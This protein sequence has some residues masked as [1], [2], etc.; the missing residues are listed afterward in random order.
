M[1][2]VNEYAPEV[3]SIVPLLPRIVH[4]SNMS[5]A[6]VIEANIDE[7]VWTRDG[8]DQ[9]AALVR[10]D[11]TDRDD[12]DSGSPDAINMRIE[13][14]R[15]ITATLATS[16][17]DY[18]DELVDLGANSSDEE[19]QVG[20]QQPPSDILMFSID[21]ERRLSVYLDDLKR[22]ALTQSHDESS[23]SS[24]PASTS[25]PT[26]GFDQSI[27]IDLPLVVAF[28][29][30]LV[31]DKG[32]MS[33]KVNL[34]VILT[35][36]RTRA[37]ELSRLDRFMTKR[38]AENWQSLSHPNAA[39]VGNNNNKLR[40]IS[41]D[42]NLRQIFANNQTA[43]IVLTIVLAFLALVLIMLVLVSIVYSISICQLF[44]GSSK[45]S[46]SNNNNKNN[47]IGKKCK[48]VTS[49]SSSSSSSCIDMDKSQLKSLLKKGGSES[50]K[51]SQAEHIGL[52]LTNF[53]CSAPPT[54][55]T[56]L[57]D[58]SNGRH[59]GLV[60]C[61]AQICDRKEDGNS[62]TNSSDTS[63][64]SSSHNPKQPLGNGCK[65][66]QDKSKVKTNIN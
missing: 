6:Y 34:V 9:T 41:F 36:N 35:N 2:D 5:T 33:T 7:L 58:Q 8:S 39:K 53:L 26:Y 60:Y 40:G 50:P 64:R 3:R 15:A 61:A 49:S 63:T 11:A 13:H 52:K 12:N 38:F 29:T 1:I 31:E 18:N 47:K 25:S 24:S 56:H 51:R 23:S 54:T 65:L 28:L 46:T 62:S 66:A 20:Q 45:R 44:T 27:D 4:T 55:T 59:V 32:E 19:D 37:D 17:S 43:F 22:F 16:R 42:Q 30:I 48:S 57:A 21:L 14:V 10:I